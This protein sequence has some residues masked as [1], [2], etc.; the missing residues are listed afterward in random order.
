MKRNIIKKGLFLAVSLS[1]IAALSACSTESS[2]NI[3]ADKEILA[4]AKKNGNKGEYINKVTTKALDY[5]T[6]IGSN[7]LTFVVGNKYY[8]VFKDNTSGNYYYITT[9]DEKVI[10]LGS[11]IDSITNQ[12]ADYLGACVVYYD[13]NTVSV[14]LHNGEPLI[15]KLQ[16]TNFE[17]THRLISE[18]TEPSGEN[19]E[20]KLVIKLSLKEDDVRYYYVNFTYQ[21]TKYKIVINETK[22]VESMF[23]PADEK[24]YSYTNNLV[25]TKDYNVYKVAEDAL[26]VLDKD[27]KFVNEILLPANANSRLT[28][29]GDH[30]L[31]QN[32]ITAS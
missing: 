1:F 5:D 31:V 13:D 9:M 17:M 14:Y 19:R 16:Y 20:S 11:N 26:L 23:L 10:N 24:E 3:F 32:V 18:I 4:Y 21:L 29:Q 7:N 25:R 2:T 8:V 30:I 22:E 27:N 15:D 28:I 12:N 6:L